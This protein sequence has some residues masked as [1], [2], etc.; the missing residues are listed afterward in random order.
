M[1]ELI[2]IIL[3]SFIVFCLLILVLNFT[4][5]EIDKKTKLYIF[6]SYIIALLLSCLLLSLNP[7][8]L[9]LILIILTFAFA[10]KG[11]SKKTKKKIY[12]SFIVTIIL[13][14]SLFM[15]TPR[16]LYYRILYFD[17][18]VKITTNIFIDGEKIEFDKK[19]LE[20]SGKGTGTIHLDNNKNGFNISFKGSEYENYD[21]HFK[22]QEYNFDLTIA[23]WNWW[24]VFRI[25]LEIYINTN[26]NTISY[27]STN[28]FIDENT[29]YKE[30]IVT[31][32]D[33]K[34]IEEINK[35]WIN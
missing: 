14:V 16:W 5:K 20:I 35:I 26:E 19:S 12:I 8:L 21:I 1:G 32:N 30:N 25:N 27:K 31:D 22:V 17:D 15:F 10:V 3:I 13:L 33:T 34:N 2:G 24:D 11:I 18:R 4:R 23:H 6:I 9:L 7:I 28:R 29:G